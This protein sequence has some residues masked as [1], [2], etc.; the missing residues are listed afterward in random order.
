MDIISSKPPKKIYADIIEKSHFSNGTKIEIN[1]DIEVDGMISFTG[2]TGMIE[3][4]GLSGANWN[5]KVPL[6][7]AEA[8]DRIAFTIHSINEKIGH[9]GP[10]GTS[11]DTGSGVFTIQYSQGQDLR[12]YIPPSTM[13]PDPIIVSLP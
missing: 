13:D 1:N 7:L 10:S 4:T 9:S 12:V 6:T 3:L 11:G 8:L 5:D 2:V